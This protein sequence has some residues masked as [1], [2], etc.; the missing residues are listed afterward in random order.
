MDKKD[1][2]ITEENQENE[3]HEIT[4]DEVMQN[5]KNIIET[6]FI[7]NKADSSDIKYLFNLCKIYKNFEPIKQ[8][9]IAT[10]ILFIIELMENEIVLF[11]EKL[12]P[13]IMKTFGQINKSINKRQNIIIDLHINFLKSQKKKLVRKDL[14]NEITKFMDSLN[15]LIYI[16]RNI[17]KYI[18]KSE[19]GEN[20]IFIEILKNIINEKNIIENYSQNQSIE[21]N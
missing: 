14:Q 7:G 3:E 17:N 20:E 6:K 13:L 10:E 16:Q 12:C 2:I 5:F 9:R 1:I 15:T 21:L 8:Q 18:R 19:Y 4:A 11:D